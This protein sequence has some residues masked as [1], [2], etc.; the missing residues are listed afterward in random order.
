[1][2]EYYILCYSKLDVRAPFD[3]QAI[4]TRICQELSIGKI[5][6]HSN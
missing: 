5:E 1:M 3:T 2:R 6:C 4:R